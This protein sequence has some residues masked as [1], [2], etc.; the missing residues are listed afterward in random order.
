MRMSA[1]VTAEQATEYGVR[2]P[3]ED[4]ERLSDSI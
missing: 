2:R 4:G 3:T 1:D